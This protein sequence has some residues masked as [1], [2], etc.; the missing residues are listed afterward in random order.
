MKKLLA[1]KG[2]WVNKKE[3]ANEVQ[4]FIKL[5]GIRM[6]FF[7]LLNVKAIYFQFAQIQKYSLKTGQ[8]LLARL[9]K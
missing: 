6:S 5:F 2:G 4:G 8:S 1:D 9:W 3:F 7:F